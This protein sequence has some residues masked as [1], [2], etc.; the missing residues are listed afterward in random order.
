ML[1]LL[2][3]YLT[4]KAWKSGWGA[5]ALIPVIASFLIGVAL[6]ASS[7]SVEAVFIPCL[8]LDIGCIVTLGV[9]SSAKRT[10]VAR[11]PDTTFQISDT[12]E[13]TL[14]D[15]TVLTEVK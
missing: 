2:E 12:A 8:L 14:T 7:E 9:M 5:V 3:I 15:D 4:Y 13:P 10:N 6:G 1:L 11:Q